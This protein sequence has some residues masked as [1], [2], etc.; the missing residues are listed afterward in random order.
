MA[1]NF[2]KQTKYSNFSFLPFV[3]YYLEVLLAKKRS[4]AKVPLDIE[5]LLR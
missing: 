1:I 4:A 5:P 2:F 3:R